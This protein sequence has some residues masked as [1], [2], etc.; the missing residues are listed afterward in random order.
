MNPEI[1]KAV[2]FILK[3]PIEISYMEVSQCIFECKRCG[4]CCTEMNGVSLGKDDILGISNHLKHGANWFRKNC[5]EID[6][7]SSEPAAYIKG[8]L[9]TGRCMFYGDE[10]C[11]I[12][13]VRPTVCRAFPLCNADESGL[14]PHWYDMC[15]GVID[16]VREIHAYALENPNQKD[17]TSDEAVAVAGMR[18]SAHLAI[19]REMGLKNMYKGLVKVMKPWDK[20]NPT[21]RSCGID[22]LARAIKLENIEGFLK[23][24][25]ERE[26]EEK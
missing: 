12:Y 13:S 18:I 19:V 16:L 7:N 6:I 4:R 23:L 11:T 25:E 22:F 3:R 20:S 24:V 17:F 8:T 26:K 5:T 15:P 21:F 10:G 9:S 2:A 1:E 14:K